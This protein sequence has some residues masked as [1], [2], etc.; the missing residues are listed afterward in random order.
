MRQESLRVFLAPGLWD[1][2]V[3][4]G[5]ERRR[6]TCR[7]DHTRKEIAARMTAALSAPIR[8]ATIRRA[9]TPRVARLRIRR[10]AR[11][12]DCQPPHAA[13]GRVD[14]RRLRRVGDQEQGTGK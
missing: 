5:G 8:R 9:A 13:D 10:P 12:L 1:D 7:S 14:C 2:R 4:G 6:P 11:L 3:G